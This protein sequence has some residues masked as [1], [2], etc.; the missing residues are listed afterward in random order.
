MNY[1]LIYIIIKQQSFCDICLE[2][3]Q[4]ED[5]KLVYCDLCNG[6]TH[7]TCYGSELLGG[8]PGI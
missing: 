8:I 2:K 4:Y 7:Q 1:I 3:D 6:L 5:D